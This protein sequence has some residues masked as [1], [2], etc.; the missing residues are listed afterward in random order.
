MLNVDEIE[1]IAML[2][3]F[4]VNGTLS[5]AECRRVDAAV[6]VSSELRDEL[7]AIGHMAHMVKTGGNAIMQ[8]D[9]GSEARL[10]A[11]QGQLDEKAPIP[12]PS[13]APSVAAPPRH[14]IGALLSFLHPKRWHPAVSLGLAVAFVAQGAVLANL[15]GGKQESEA[16]IASLQKRVGDLEFQLAS[17]PGGQA[18]GNIIIEVRSDASWSDVEALLGEE[19]LSIVGG[20]SDGAITLSSLATGA[21]L[22]AQIERLRASPLV[23][24]VDKG[25]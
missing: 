18:I 5:A 6:A 16:Q 12:A 7:A 23:A 24:S 14:N 10:D 21:T 3:P 4:Y 20:P 25:A 1:D 11:V 8:A 15:S 19:G 13:P 9:E 2:L 22:D 17:G